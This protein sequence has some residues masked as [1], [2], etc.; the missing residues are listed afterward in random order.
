MRRSRAPVK[1]AA[2]LRRAPDP[3]RGREAVLNANTLED[4]G[5]ARDPRWA[6]VIPSSECSNWKRQWPLVPTFSHGTLNYGTITAPP[7]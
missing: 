7:R 1:A 5:P 6:Q 4:T 3:L 2:H